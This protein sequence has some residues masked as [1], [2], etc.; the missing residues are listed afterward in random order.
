MSLVACQIREHGEGPVSVAFSKIGREGCSSKVA[1][2]EQIFSCKDTWEAIR[3]KKPRVEWSRIIWYPLFIPKHAFF[4]WLTF[5]DRLT[6]GDKMLKWGV[7]GSS[8][9]CFVEII[10]KLKITFSL[11]VVL[12]TGF[13]E[14][15]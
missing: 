6:T 4:L 15:S 10:W 9:V 13:G 11:S 1:G 14:L 12:V 2:K 7:W 3:E 5:K 8:N